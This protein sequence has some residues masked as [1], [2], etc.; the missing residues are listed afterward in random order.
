[1]SASPS[2]FDASASALG[3]LYQCRY[4]L[5]LALQKGDDLDLGISVEKLDDVAFHGA[6]SSP[7]NARELL[8][9]KHHVGKRGTLGDGSPDV[10]KSLN[11]WTEAAQSKRID[12][13]RVT[14]CLV[15][16]SQATIRNAVR[17]LRPDPTTRKPLEALER[18]M[19][20]GATSTN[21]AVTDA[22]NRFASLTDLDRRALVNAVVL[23]D[24]ASNIID[25]DGA[26]RSAVRY[27]ADPKHRNA[28]VERLEGWWLQRLVRHLSDPD[29]NVVPVS[30]IQR[31]VYE[32]GSLFRRECLPDDLSGVASPDNAH[33]N[34]DDRT[35]VRQL[36]LIGL[37]DA[38]LRYAQ[39]DHYRAFTQRSRWVKDQ[40]IDLDE[41]TAYE[42]RL[43]EGWEERFA[44]M[45]E[46]VPHGSEEPTRARHG[47]RFY[48]W[49]VSEA[50]TKG[51]FWLR[52]DFQAE[53]M[54][55]GSYHML[56]DVLRVGWHPDYLG[57][58]STLDDHGKG[59]AS[60]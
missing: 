19:E 55:K 20:A 42:N 37:S 31:Q 50:P 52:P 26:L 46:E 53:Y 36:G 59:D 22:F 5:L 60:C 11:I 3:Y 47:L 43:V 2:A 10:W 1:M 44:I 56:A 14:L 12:L 34:D 40:L 35:F 32:I 29:P 27:A 54:T 13:N 8:Q 28:L 4:A 38:R 15:T 18:L 23:L 21:Q 45:N 39:S 57:L 17:L 25:L 49:I 6:P 48:N 33:P 7:E 30:T 58:L 9:F 41:A 51:S 24:G 16:T